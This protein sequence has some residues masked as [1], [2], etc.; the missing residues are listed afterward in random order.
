VKNILHA[1]GST[2]LFNIF[3]RLLELASSFAECV[4]DFLILFLL[5]SSANGSVFDTQIS[6]DQHE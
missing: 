3:I 5:A 6:S 4:K 2:K 1:F